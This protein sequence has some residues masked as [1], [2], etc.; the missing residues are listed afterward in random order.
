VFQST[1]NHP[2]NPVSTW[3]FWISETAKLINFTVITGT[4]LAYCQEYLVLVGSGLHIG[5]AYRYPARILLAHFE[6]NPLRYSRDCLLRFLDG[7]LKR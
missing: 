7:F 3:R 4:P 2:E 6:N 1:R 5:S